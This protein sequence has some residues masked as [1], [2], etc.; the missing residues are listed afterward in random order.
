[1]PAVHKR[2]S[3]D[4]KKKNYWMLSGSLISWLVKDRWITHTL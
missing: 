4:E 1:M 3:T 2:V